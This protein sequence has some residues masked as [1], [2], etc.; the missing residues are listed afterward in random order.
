MSKPEP[1]KCATD[2][3][4]SAVNAHYSLIQLRGLINNGP[5]PNVTLETHQDLCAEIQELIADVSETKS[6]LDTLW[7]HLETYLNGEDYRNE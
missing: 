6:R 2:A 3:F 7:S 4:S 1:L 5:A